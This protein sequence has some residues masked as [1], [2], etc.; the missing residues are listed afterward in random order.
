MMLCNINVTFNVFSSRRQ[1]KHILILCVIFGHFLKII[2]C[3]MHLVLIGPS[4]KAKK[5]AH[6]IFEYCFFPYIFE[7]MH[8]C[9]SSRVDERWNF[10]FLVSSHFPVNFCLFIESSF[11]AT[12]CHVILVNTTTIFVELNMNSLNSWLERT[13]KNYH[14][15]RY[16]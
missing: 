2:F 10:Q 9:G 1:T 5:C 16:K 4:L 8:N 7:V 12:F 13:R 14:V 11:N 3:D 6:V 15:N